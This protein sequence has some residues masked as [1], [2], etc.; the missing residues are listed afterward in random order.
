MIEGLTI[1]MGLVLAG[2]AQ[3]AAAPRAPAAEILASRSTE[4]DGWI[5]LFNG[6]DLSGWYTFL[7]KYG[8]NQDPDNVITIEDGAI[9]LYKHAADGSTVVMGYIGTDREFGDY[10]LRFQFRW[11]KKKFQPRYALKRDAGLYY[12]LTGPDA[13]W[14]RALQFQVEQTNVGDLIALHGMQLDTWIDASTRGAEQPTYRSPEQGGEP[15]VLGGKGIAYQKRWPGA[16]EL[17]GWNTV[18]VI[19][20]ADTTVHRLNGQVVNQGRNVRFQ[21][22]EPGTS[23]RPLTRGK[24]ALEIEAAEIEFRQVEIRTLTADPRK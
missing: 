7:Q 14:P 21:P 19:A 24:I 22:P 6:R 10:H 1:V 18:E 2:Q 3:D 4:A 20:R 17:E 11:G 8:K 15:R 23:P 5:K 9:H 16:V 13:V 12:H